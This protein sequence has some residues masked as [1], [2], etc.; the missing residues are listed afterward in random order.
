[1]KIKN[2]PFSA[3]G[4]LSFI[5][6]IWFGKTPAM[7][8][9][10]PQATRQT[11]ETEIFVSRPVAQAQPTAQLSTEPL[12]KQA[13]QLYETGQFPQAIALLKQLGSDYAAKGD[14]LGQARISR[15][16][17]LIYQQTGEWKT[18][19]EAIT[20]SLHSL[21]G[22]SESRERTKLLAEALEVQGKLQLSVGESEQALENLAKSRQHL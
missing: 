20:D 6:V 11:Q 7:S 19:T 13:E 17:S 9:S 21:Q 1:M 10:F 3:L 16:L 18:A 12:E 8:L 15:N 4:I 14:E 22:Q 5:C 2:L